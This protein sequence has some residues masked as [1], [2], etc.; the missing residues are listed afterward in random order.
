MISA[1]IICLLIGY[2]CGN[3]LTAEIVSYYFTGGSTAGI[4]SGNP[5]MANVMINI[6]KAPG[7]LVLVGDILK[8]IL[9]MGITYLIF[10]DRIAALSI[11]YAGMGTVLGHDFPFWKKMK[12]GKGVT[13]T[14]TWYILSF[15]GWG[16]LSCTLGLVTV[17]LTGWLP[18]AA[19]LITFLMFPLAFIFSGVEAGIL[20]VLNALLMCVKHRRGLKRII[21]RTEKRYTLKL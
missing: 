20:T 3:F 18:L 15:G 6:G 4:G 8:T 1:R 7:I 9:A 14:C 19:I 5:G 21:N 2:I 12:G 10:H 13:V 11:Q 17:L 16:I